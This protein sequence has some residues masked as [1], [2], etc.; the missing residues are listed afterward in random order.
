ML[1]C[2]DPAITSSRGGVMK[3]LSADEEYEAILI[4]RYRNKGELDTSWQA[5]VTYISYTHNNNE[6]TFT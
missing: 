4:W 2:V 6:R 5:N 1:A 3:Y